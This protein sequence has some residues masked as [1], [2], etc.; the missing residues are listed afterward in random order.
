M[1]DFGGWL[2]GKVK[3]IWNWH[4]DFGGWLW[5]KVKSIWGGGSNDNSGGGRS[6]GGLVGK[7]FV[8][9]DGM[10]KLHRGES[11]ITKGQS[12]NTSN[13]SI[14]LKPTIQIMGGNS[15]I[16]P[17]ELARRFSNITMMELKSRGIA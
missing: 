10:Y 6:S 4:W 17:D 1:M 12:N 9:S 13:Q 8:P 16:D 5:S 11:V 14:I 15:N 7:A 2:W 3:S